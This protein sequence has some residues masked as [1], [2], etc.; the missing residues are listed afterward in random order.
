MKTAAFRLF[1]P[2]IALSTAA[3]SEE[4]TTPHLDVPYVPTNAKLVEE[5]LDMVNLKDGDVVWDLGCGDGRLLIAA[6]K[7]KA[8]RGVG[9][10]IDPKRIEESKANA[11]K[12]GVADRV[13]FR[14]ADLFETD[15]SDATVLTMYLLEQI[16]RKL[17]PT[18][19]NDL[20]PG[21]R[22]V[23][24]TFTMGEWA[25]DAR[26][27]SPD[28][29]SQSTAYYW[30]VPA[31]ITGEWSW[32]MEGKQGTLSIDQKFQFFSGTS[33]VGGKSHEFTDGAIQGNG[34]TF[35][36]EVPDLGK[37]TFSATANGDSL[38]ATVDGKTW[39][40]NRKPESRKP[41]DTAVAE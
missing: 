12:E 32:S 6:A 41:L 9:V 16:N 26:H 23:S 19:L 37:T 11:T 15:F 30:M 38:T 18:I 35:S 5:M 20:Q 1:A 40:A 17:R 10:D 24:N 25:P 22:I 28:D 8:V 27:D 2:C 29:I 33:T 13:T 7:R 39:R 4:T 31:N 34:V 3:C 21:T 14:V 36:A